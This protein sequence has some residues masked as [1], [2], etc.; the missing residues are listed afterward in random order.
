MEAYAKTGS[1]G[2]EREPDHLTNDVTHSCLS[3]G[4]P[5]NMMPPN[6]QSEALLLPS[7]RIADVNFEMVIDEHLSSALQKLKDL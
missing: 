7:D 5:E 6:S 1:T 3:G 4:E 2:A